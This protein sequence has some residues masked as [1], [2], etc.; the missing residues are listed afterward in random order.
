M[1]SLVLGLIAVAVGYPAGVLLWGWVQWRR[2]R[3]PLLKP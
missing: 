3:Q 2:G 1:T